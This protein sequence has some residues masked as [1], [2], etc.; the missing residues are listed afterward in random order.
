MAVISH[1]HFD[2]GGGMARFLELN[3]HAK[4]Y[5]RRAGAR[6]PILPFSRQDSSHRHR[7]RFAGTTPRSFCRARGDNRDQPGRHPGHGGRMP[8]S[9]T[10]RQRPSSRPAG[11]SIGG[12]WLRPRIDH[13]APRRRW[14][15]GGHPVL[16]QRCPQHDRRCDRAVSRQTAQG[17]GRRLSPHRSADRR[18]HGPEPD[19]RSRTSA[20]RS[21]HAATARF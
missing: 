14:H 21:V 9:P 19:P 10:A 2:H 6:G 13:G 17:G 4:V 18:F 15:G 7:S 3:H 1:Q 16:T 12:R 20:G 5:L 8:L 11:R